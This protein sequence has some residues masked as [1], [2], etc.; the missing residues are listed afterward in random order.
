MKEGRKPEYPEKTP[1]NVPQTHVLCELQIDEPDLP[2]RPPPARQEAD[3]SPLTST[4]LKADLPSGFPPTS[5]N[6]TRPSA[7][8]PPYTATPTPAP[9]TQGGPHS[10]ISVDEGTSARQFTSEWIVV[11]YT[12][13]VGDE[14]VIGSE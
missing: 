6:V 2:A 1:D 10:V 12:C 11:W 8:V 4:P 9:S 5:G 14:G 3:V 7:Q 13:G